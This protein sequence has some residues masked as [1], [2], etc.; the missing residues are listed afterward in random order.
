MLSTRKLG[1]VKTVFENRLLLKNTGILNH[2]KAFV[3]LISSF[4][5]TLS[6]FTQYMQDLS[7]FAAFMQ[8]KETKFHNYTDFVNPNFSF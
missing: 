1:S 2:W 5:I 6:A 3:T 7:Y 8:A 4:G